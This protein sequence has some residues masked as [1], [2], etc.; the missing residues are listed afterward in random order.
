[1]TKRINIL[2]TYKFIL[3]IL[4]Q[5]LLHNILFFYI[6]LISFN[7][8]YS[9]LTWYITTTKDIYYFYLMFSTSIF[10]GALYLIICYIAS[11]LNKLEYFNYNISYLKL[12]KK[13]IKLD[14]IYS[15]V[16]HENNLINVNLTTLTH[17]LTVT[18]HTRLYLYI[19]INEIYY[20]QWWYW[21]FMVCYFLYLIDI[22]IL[23]LFTY[24]GFFGKNP[25]SSWREGYQYRVHIYQNA[26]RLSIPEY[27]IN[28]VR[29][30]FTKLYFAIYGY[31]WWP[32]EETYMN[33]ALV[34]TLIVW[35]WTLILNFNFLP[36]NIYELK[37]RNIFGI[38]TCI[39]MEP[40]RIPSIYYVFHSIINILYLTILLIFILLLF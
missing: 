34:Y 39:L 22:T 10:F 1:M 28:L 2:K 37:D 32:T 30:L 8:W 5:P 14:D 7:F 27:F 24:N 11:K 25:E 13:F 31:N 4:K 38:I 26:R 21:Y 29:P 3:Q 23:Y 19:I 18:I 17:F 12:D 15:W 9:I 35:P 6:F 16:Y 33:E 36:I 20:H 40:D